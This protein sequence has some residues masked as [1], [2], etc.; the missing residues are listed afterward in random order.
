MKSFTLFR[1]HLEM[2]GVIWQR[3]PHSSNRF[4]IKNLI[5]LALAITEVYCLMKT[6]PDTDSFEEYTETVYKAVFMCTIAAI[7]FTIVW[8]TPELFNYIDKLENYIGNRE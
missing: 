7:Y 1:E 2:C 4:N 3:L 8:E 6:L 5:F